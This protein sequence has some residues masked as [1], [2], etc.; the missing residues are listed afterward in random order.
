[1]GF[2]SIVPERRLGTRRER[3]REPASA[4]VRRVQREWIRE[5]I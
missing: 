1:V 5:W 3:T 2:L 4:R